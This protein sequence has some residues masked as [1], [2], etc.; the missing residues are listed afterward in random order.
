M[1]S[2]TRESQESEIR[3]TRIVMNQEEGVKER[4]EVKGAQ[5]SQ[6]IDTARMRR[7]EI[8]REKE[9]IKIGPPTQ[10]ERKKGGMRVGLV[11][12]GSLKINLKGVRMIIQVV[13]RSGEAQKGVGIRGRTKKEEQSLEGKTKEEIGVAQKKKVVMRIE[14]ATD[15]V[16]I[17]GKTMKEEQSQV[18]KTKVR[19]IE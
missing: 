1:K 18:E 14:E 5:Q 8:G 19:R 12:V 15:G 13:E 16:E 2:I 11:G 3:T 9:K 4:E 6:R 7:A 10:K 17:R